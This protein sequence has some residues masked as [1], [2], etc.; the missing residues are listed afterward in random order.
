[1]NPIGVNQNKK[2]SEPGKINSLRNWIYR[3]L[4]SLVIGCIV[5][6]AF[7]M[8][9]RYFITNTWVAYEMPP[10]VRAELS[11]LQKNPESNPGRYH[12]I[13]DKWFGISYSDPSIATSDWLLLLALVMIAAP[14]LFFI[15][16]RSVRPISVHISRLAS[17]ARAITRGNFGVRTAVPEELPDELKRLSEDINVMSSQLSRYER[18]LKASNVALAH[19][20]RSPL[21]ASIGRLQGMLD[22]VFEPSQDQLNMVMRQLQVLNHLVDDLH[23]LSLADAGQLH[24]N[25]TSCNVGELIREKIAW[26]RPRLM[27]NDISVSLLN[28]PEVQ[29]H[30]DA[31]RL[32]QVLLVLLDNAIRYAADGKVIEVEYG[33]KEE[34]LYISC[35]DH[36][37]GVSDEFMKNIFVRFSRA[38]V[39]RARHSGGSGLGLSIA[40]TI[41]Q[42]HG[43]GLDAHRN[44]HGGMTFIVKI[45]KHESESNLCF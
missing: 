30:A 16:L 33:L 38:D 43:G 11:L 5:I 2:E 29:C 23:L 13:T 22:G 32:G 45:P 18:E 1:M 41:C 39:S 20:L 8:W 37:P 36:G 10:E 4:F 21:T 3:R 24:L 19:E 35:S 6:I 14:I 25:R 28:Q 44:Q 31:F 40:A 15:M 12:E 26:V 42:A 17:V 34:H 7:C 9:F 27:E